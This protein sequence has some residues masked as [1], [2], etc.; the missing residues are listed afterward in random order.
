MYFYVRVQHG[1]IFFILDIPQSGINGL[2][3]RAV[4]WT[5]IKKNVMNA[6]WLRRFWGQQ[7]SMLLLYLRWGWS[8][9]RSMLFAGKW[10][11][12]LSSDVPDKP[13]SHSISN[14]NNP[15]DTGYR[16]TEPIDRF[17][18]KRWN[19]SIDYTKKA[20]QCC[21]CEHDRLVEQSDIC[22]SQSKNPANRHRCYR[23]AARRSGRR[24]RKCISGV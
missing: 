21:T 16:P 15:V 9:R 24:S 23:I 8:L 4:L 18:L 13:K 7:N 20:K 10:M 5:T 11:L 1:K 3:R 12:P 17:D 6:K 22:D 14:K 2:L 19:I